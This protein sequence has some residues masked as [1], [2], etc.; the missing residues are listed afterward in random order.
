MPVAKG[1]CAVVAASGDADRTALLLSC[2]TPIG[3]RIVGDGVVKLRGGLVVPGT[4][5]GAAVDR[6][7]CALI[8]DQQNDVAVVGIDPEILIVVSTGSA[9]KTGPGFAAIGGAH[10]DGAGDVN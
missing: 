2:A 3:K 8:A 10:G 1:D 6:D 7:E 4:P 5:G 9:A